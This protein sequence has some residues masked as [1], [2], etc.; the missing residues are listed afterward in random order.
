MAPD[1]PRAPPANDAGAD[2]TVGTAAF[3]RAASMPSQRPVIKTRVEW[4]MNI[5]LFMTMVAALTAPVG[6]NPLLRG[7]VAGAAYFVQQGAIRAILFRRWSAFADLPILAYTVAGMISMALLYSPGLPSALR[8]IPVLIWGILNLLTTHRVVA[9]ARNEDIVRSTIVP[10]VYWLVTGGG[11]PRA[12]RD[13][14]YQIFRADPSTLPP[15]AA[16]T[17]RLFESAAISLQAPLLFLYNRQVKGALASFTTREQDIRALDPRQFGLDAANI[18]FFGRDAASVARDPEMIDI[19]LAH[20]AGHLARDA[21]ASAADKRREN[22]LLR[23]VGSGWPKALEPLKGTADLVVQAILDHDVVGYQIATGHPNSAVG[24][25]KWSI[26]AA[27]GPQNEQ[28]IRTEPRSGIA[29]VYALNY[30]RG[31]RLLTR[32]NG[33]GAAE[34]LRALDQTF[35]ARLSDRHRAHVRKVVEQVYGAALSDGRWRDPEVFV[36]LFQQLLRALVSAE[37]LFPGD[38]AALTREETYAAFPNWPRWAVEVFIAPWYESPD[39]FDPVNFLASHPNRG[40]WPWIGRIAGTAF[41]LFGMTAV[42]FLLGQMAGVSAGASFPDAWGFAL[43]LISFGSGLALLFDGQGRAL[44]RSVPGLM[45]IRRDGKVVIQRPPRAG[46]PPSL[47]ALL[48]VFATPALVGSIA[49]HFVY[50]VLSQIT[51]LFGRA[52][53]APLTMEGEPVYGVWNQDAELLDL[54]RRKAR[55]ETR[56]RELRASLSAPGSLPS[57]RTRDIERSAAILE[58]RAREFDAWSQPLRKPGLTA[59]EF[60]AFLRRETGA[61]TDTE[62]AWLDGATKIIPDFPR[63]RIFFVDGD[64]MLGR[65]YLKDRN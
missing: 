59:D 3:A 8:A 43:S 50:N 44:N 1:A 22:E 27:S 42:P 64:S 29:L 25:L 53:L 45:A 56:A 2:T 38:T 9:Q 52:R 28:V 15:V 39:T 11:V 13:R 31:A 4:M 63:D 35:G 49:T 30:L 54:D 47:Q 65:L 40:V 5:G 55:M 61:P 17:R 48:A 14:A 58:A 37:A 34:T 24:Y 62:A 16:E 26:R 18:V 51:R 57:I 32:M 10:G 19:A 7:L 23:F 36:G 12:F 46:L 21:A 60:L 6:V 33:N 41:I 20:E